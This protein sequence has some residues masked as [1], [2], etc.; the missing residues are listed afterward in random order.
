MFSIEKL[1]INVHMH[2]TLKW[3]NH[4]LSIVVCTHRHIHAY[5]IR[6]IDSISH[7]TD[8]VRSSFFSL[9]KSR[10][11]ALIEKYPFCA[12]VCVYSEKERKS[13]KKREIQ[14]NEVANI[15][16]RFQ[17]IKINEIEIVASGEIIQKNQNSGGEKTVPLLACL[18]SRGSGNVW[19]RHLNVVDYAWCALELYWAWIQF[20]SLP[21]LARTIFCSI[22]FILSFFCY[23]FVA[24]KHVTHFR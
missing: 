16:T 9:Q 10:K 13:G 1:L 18:C 17:S 5:S 22:Y 3:I 19:I 24:C 12:R 21:P 11:S 14:S 8:I 23:S 2:N 20:F 6:Q 7:S 15:F 4:S